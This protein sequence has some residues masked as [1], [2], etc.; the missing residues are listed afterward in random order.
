MQRVTDEV[1]EVFQ[2]KM[3]SLGFEIALDRT[4]KDGSTIAVKMYTLPLMIYKK[5]KIDVDI[6][7]IIYNLIVNQ[8]KVNSNCFLKIFMEI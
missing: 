2:K 3:E 6:E 8:L 4:G 1:L 7:S 5:L